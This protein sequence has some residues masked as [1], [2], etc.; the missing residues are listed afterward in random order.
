[1]EKKKPPTNW[2]SRYLTTTSLAQAA[3]PKS[4]RLAVVADDRDADDLLAQVWPLRSP[5]RAISSGAY[6]ERRRKERDRRP[7]SR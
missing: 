2:N 3:N 1:M 5:P 4:I 7:E 6:S